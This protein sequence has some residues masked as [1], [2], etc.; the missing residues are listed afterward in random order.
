MDKYLIP[1]CLSF[2]ISPAALS[3][4]RGSVSAARG[5]GPVALV[6]NHKSVAGAFS[7]RPRSVR[8]SEV[9]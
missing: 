4:E 6:L 9:D 2:L 5:S 8:L 3:M 7:A 1:A